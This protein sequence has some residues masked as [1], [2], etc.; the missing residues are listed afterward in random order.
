MGL[1]G[2]FMNSAVLYS[3]DIYH[4]LIIHCCGLAEISANGRAY[5][6]YHVSLEFLTQSYALKLKNDKRHKKAIDSL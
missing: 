4:T 2:E 5:I 1:C 3:Q 6:H